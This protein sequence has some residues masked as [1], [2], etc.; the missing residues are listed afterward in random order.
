MRCQPQ[1]EPT[2]NGCNASYARYTYAT[3]HGIRL[4]GILHNGI[5][6]PPIPVNLRALVRRH[7]KVT[8]RLHTD[9]MN[10]Q[11]VKLSGA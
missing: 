4:T 9:P 5:G 10:I 7:V 2:K 3:A 1:S 11:Y 8:S 6:H